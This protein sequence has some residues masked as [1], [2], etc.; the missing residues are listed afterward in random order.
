M[1]DWARLIAASGGETDTAVTFL[2]AGVQPFPEPL[3]AEQELPVRERVL[4]FQA[5]AS[6]DAAAL[7]GHI[8]VAVPT[9]P[10][11]QLIQQRILPQ[12]SPRD[13]AQVLLS[14]LLVASDVVPGLY[15]FVPGARAALLETLPR[16]QSQTT[17]DTLEQISAEIQER[18]GTVARTFQAIVPVADGTGNLTAEVG[19]RPFA[20]V[21]TEA[22]RILSH[23]AIPAFD[24]AS[25]KGL[26]RA[27]KEQRTQQEIA[28]NADNDVPNVAEITRSQLGAAG[29]RTVIPPAQ[30]PTT[31]V[32]RFLAERAGG[33]ATHSARDSST[34]PYPPPDPAVPGTRL[35]MFGAPG[36]GKTSFL[37]SLQIALLRQPDLGWALTADNPGSQQ[38][39]I[40]FL[41]QMTLERRF[42]QLT[43]M[44]IENY[45]WTLRADLPRA[46]REW[47]WWGF[48]RRSQQVKIPLDLIDPPGWATDGDL[49]SGRPISKNLV[50]DLARSAGIVLFFD[51]I[52]ESA[53]GDT[54]RHTYHV[55]T[56]LRSQASHR[57]KLPHYVAVCITKFDEISVFRSA[58]TLRI[59]DYGMEEPNF[60]QVPDE[61]AKEFFMRLVRVS[62]SDN[63]SLILPL[64]EQSF[65]HE[66]VRFFVTSA[67]G[68][69]V[70]PNVGTFDLQD[71]QNHIPGKPDHIRGEVR[72]INVLEPVL[73]LCR[74]IAATA[75]NQT[76]GD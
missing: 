25:E 69:Y 41:D 29:P 1:A 15:D 39:L 55:L 49:L 61:H 24:A 12:S 21:S 44:Q 17:A 51:P 45:R 18:A 65:H 14:G 71:Y 9:L 42:P 36:S 4:R 66:R 5:A 70:D 13:L 47:H 30:Q 48:R 63:A 68:F 74:N 6:P 50:A 46:V 20:F 64:L 52:G 72:P 31:S 59:V 35:V 56:Q 60:P 7:A 38:A 32:S 2:S 11:M 75:G 28:N 62:R 73:W 23:T 3:I 37:A 53:R 58:Q 67:I 43:R 34:D 26:D 16:H 54:L 76:P 57:G 10:V 8:A 19:Q 27:A 40:S 33:D 22:L